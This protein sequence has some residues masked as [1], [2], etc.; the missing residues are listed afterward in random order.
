MEDKQD[1]FLAEI[2]DVPTNITLIYYIQVHL[3]NGEEVI[4]NNDGKYFYY[5]V[6]AP[7][8]SFEESD[9]NQ[10]QE[11]IKDVKEYEYRE[12]EVPPKRSEYPVEDFNVFK[13]QDSP[14]SQETSTASLTNISKPEIP[15][16]KNPI[17]YESE[18]HIT[19]F[20][21]QQTE[22]DP[23]LKICS[24]CNSKIKKMWSTCP[25]CGKDI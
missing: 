2:S 23:D 7:I 3:V 12:K 5:K 9:Y 17:K 21:R 4:E 19:I 22:I 16:P 8:G 18:N 20:G 13:Q 24:Y 10:Q 25:I 11:D 6:G 15:A 14:I 1:Y